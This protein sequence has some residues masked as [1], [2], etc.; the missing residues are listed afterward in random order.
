[1]I[2]FFVY[3]KN[4]TKKGLEWSLGNDF[5]LSPFDR[6]HWRFF[7]LQKFSSAYLQNA[8]LGLKN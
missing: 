8:F 7:N 4:E 5:L 2:N 6:P 1:M 3:L